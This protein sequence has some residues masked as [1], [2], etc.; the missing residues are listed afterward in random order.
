MTDWDVLFRLPSIG[1]VRR[2]TWNGRGAGKSEAMIGTAPLSFDRADEQVESLLAHGMTFTRVEDA[3][4][5]AGLTQA[6]KAALWLLAWSLR[7][8]S[9]QVRDAR[10]MAR[11]FVSHY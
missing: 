9:L 7:E 3:I 2:S 11:G 8:T 6:H 1:T 10:Q 4:D 5:A